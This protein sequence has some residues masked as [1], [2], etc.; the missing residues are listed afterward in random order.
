MIT[1]MDEA[2]RLHYMSAEITKKET[3]KV[4][5]TPYTY[6]KLW[7]FPFDFNF[8]VWGELIYPQWKASSHPR[9]SAQSLFCYRS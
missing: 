9:A 5:E 4:S 2:P 3:E 6:H 7:F 1:E 8:I